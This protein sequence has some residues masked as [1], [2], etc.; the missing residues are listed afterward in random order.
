[1]DLPDSHFNLLG[2][3]MELILQIVEHEVHVEDL[4]N[5]ALCSKTIFNIAIRSRRKHLENKRRFTMIIVGGKSRAGDLKPHSVHPALALQLLVENDAVVDYCKFLKLG[6]YIGFWNIPVDKEQE[7]QTDMSHPL[8]ALQAKQPSANIDLASLHQL[9]GPELQ[10]IAYS[11][12]ISNLRNLEVLE[13]DHCD[14]SFVRDHAIPDVISDTHHR[15]KEVR[16]L[17]VPGSGEDLR[18]VAMFASIPSVRKIYGLWTS[19]RDV[20]ALRAPSDI[21]DLY[22]E[23]SKIDGPSFENLLMSIKTLKQFYYKNDYAFSA[24]HPHEPR[25]LVNSLRAHA[26][27]SLERLSLTDPTRRYVSWIYDEDRADMV[28]P[29][30]LRDFKALKH[31][32]IECSMFKKMTVEHGRYLKE[33]LRLIDVLPPTL[34]TLVLYHPPKGNRDVKALFSG[35]GPAMGERL[36]NLRSIQVMVWENR[37][38]D[39]D[40]KD[41]EGD[42]RELGIQ[43]VVTKDHPFPIS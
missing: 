10:N 15:L 8:R 14:W 18:Y 23:R 28:R 43:L 31:V 33:K 19:G 2:L 32:A 21:E 39:L 41:I 25:R 35:L 9:P 16:V 17:G 34:E 12:I 6:D 3:P 27:E 24:Q 40:S 37:W 30:F 13:I 38:E 7:F 1:M 36:P 11:A 20:E 5:L 26:L 4:E 42:C 29:W 22:F